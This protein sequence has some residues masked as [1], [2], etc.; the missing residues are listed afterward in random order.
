MN[1]HK[2]DNKLLSHENFKNLKIEGREDKLRNIS[3]A[4]FASAKRTNTD[5]NLL[6]NLINKGYAFDTKKFDKDLLAKKTTNV[7]D[8]VHKNLVEFAKLIFTKKS[9]GTPNA[10][11]GKGELM[12]I[13]L[14]HDFGNPKKGDVTLFNKL[15][16]IKANGG[17][18]GFG[19]G[20]EINKSLLERCKKLG[21]DLPKD[22]RGRS[23]FVPFNNK[24]IGYL[25]D[26]YERVLQ[27]WVKVVTGVERTGC[28]T[29][30]QAA[31]KIIPTVIKKSNVFRDN[32]V[33]LTITATG[34]CKAYYGESDLIKNSKYFATK[35]K[36]EYR[37][38]QKNKL[39]IYLGLQYG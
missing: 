7:F 31:I 33:L 12:F 10:A 13:L 25:K 3:D 4:I 24:H 8:Y 6:F 37:C 16:E 2:L 35:D 19:A 23:E 5:L 29:F 36:W 38:H 14:S 17:K 11:S 1:I 9:I 21:I 39:A 30:N 34:D 18:I 32:D 28:K 15:Y 27:E 22:K 20:S 26:N